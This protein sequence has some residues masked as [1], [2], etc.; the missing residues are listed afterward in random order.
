MSNIKKILVPFDYSE[1]AINALDYA[2]NFAGYQRPIEVVALQVTQK[3]MKDSEKVEANEE[4]KKIVKS[5]NKR[6]HKPPRL[7]LLSGDLIDTILKAQNDQKIE[8]TIMGTM[9]DSQANEALTNASR[10]VL[11]AK[12][13]VITVPYGC[14]ITLPKQIS[15]VLGKE[16]IERP[17]VLSTLLDI[18]RMFNAKVHVLT[19][20]KES[21]YKE[22]AVV[23]SNEDTLEY[24]LEHFY[25]EHNFS[26]NED[27]EKGI[28]DY[29]NDKGIELLAILPRNHAQ[30][31]KA[32]EGR[33][34]KLLT[35]HSTVPVLT[36]D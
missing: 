13:P 25:A 10:L 21:I 34:T 4:F 3:E 27:I 33:L 24:Y 18:A 5:L 29:I 30:K 16:E 31:T 28:L 17:K 32:S 7:V 9:G 23:E 1:P 22:E 35:L 2:L 36:L 8:L 6:T 26:K 12:G 11:E 19:I 20:Y 15:L 14:E